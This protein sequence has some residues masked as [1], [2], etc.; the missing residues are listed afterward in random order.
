MKKLIFTEASGFVFSRFAELTVPLMKSYAQRIGADFIYQEKERKSKYPLYGK[1][2]VFNLLN[3]YDRVL[4]LDV[5]I[6]VRP[7][8]PDIFSIVPQGNFAAFQEGAWCDDNELLARKEL[9]QKIANAHNIEILDFDMTK[10]YFNAGV[11]LVDKKH[12]DLFLM[13]NENPIMSEITSE[14]NLLN[15]RLFYSKNKT[16][17]LPMCFN[18]M[19]F[20]W[21]RWYIE[22][23][24]F[25]HYA[26]TPTDIRFKTIN[27]DIEYIKKNFE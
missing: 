8:S 15:L 21:S 3:E 26:G 2:E 13:P 11:F 27:Q 5:D 16:Y 12:K 23:S 7:D 25:I 20:R 4:F 24:Y 17:H 6:I 1:Y 22:D 19:P 14:Q 10:N 9:L 18:S